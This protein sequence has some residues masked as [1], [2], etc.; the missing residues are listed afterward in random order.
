MESYDFF[1]VQTQAHAQRQLC[2]RSAS[3]WNQNLLWFI[4]QFSAHQGDVAGRTSEHI[5]GCHAKSSEMRIPFQTE[6]VRF[7]L[8][9]KA[10]EFL[11]W[12]KGNDDLRSA[13]NTFILSI[14]A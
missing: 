12:M 8:L 6:Q 2:M 13:C 11:P 9:Q 14:M 10:G 7:F 4:R 1:R 3:H 5:I